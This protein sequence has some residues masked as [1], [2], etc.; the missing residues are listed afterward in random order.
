MPYAFWAV[1][2][3]VSLTNAEIS[4][5]KKNSFLIGMKYKRKILNFFKRRLLPDSSAQCRGGLSISCQ[6]LFSS[7]SGRNDPGGRTA[8]WLSSITL[9]ESERFMSLKSTACYELGSEWEQNRGYL[10]VFTDCFLSTDQ[11]TGK[12]KSY[13]KTWAG[14]IHMWALSRD[15]SFIK[16]VAKSLHIKII[17]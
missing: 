2:I 12:L 13:L 1:C 7:F 17:G 16:V 15:Q 6:V 11:K 8:G 10:A 9:W 4:R 3:F 14:N 5:G